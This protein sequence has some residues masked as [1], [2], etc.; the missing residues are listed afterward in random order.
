MP[1]FSSD[2]WRVY[3]NKL[4]VFGT[5]G[6]VC[7]LNPPVEEVES[8]EDVGIAQGGVEV[9]AEKVGSCVMM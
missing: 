8:G 4:R 3:G 1:K 5:E 9:V 2:F 6:G 7:L